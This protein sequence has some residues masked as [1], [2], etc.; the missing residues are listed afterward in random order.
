MSI[1]YN[2]IVVTGRLTQDP[3]SIGKG[4]TTVAALSLASNYLDKIDGE[5]KEAVSF[6]D[7][8]AFGKT[9][10]FVLQYLTKGAAVLVAGKVSLRKYESNGKEGSTLQIRADAV[11]ALG[12]KKATEAA[13]F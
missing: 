9:A 3:K 7:V 1:D 10:D 4:E 2:N 8:L 6:F 13:P 12:P 11:Q 5:Y